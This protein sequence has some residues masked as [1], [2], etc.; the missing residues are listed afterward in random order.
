MKVAGTGLLP[1]SGSLV[2]HS[3]VSRSRV[4]GALAVVAYLLLLAVATAVPAQEP[5]RTA[6]LR[7]LAESVPAPNASPI[8]PVMSGRPDGPVQLTPGTIFR[9][10]RNCPDMVVVPAGAYMMGSAAGESERVQVPRRYR[11]RAEPRHEV[12]IPVPFAI[13]RNEL[14][15][16]DF[17]RFV[18]ATGRSVRGCWILTPRGWAFRPDLGWLNP[19]FPQSDNDPV[20]C[21]SWEDAH[22]YTYWLSAQ[23][24]Q[25]YRL[26]T[27]A[28]WEYVARA[29]T[30][31]ARP[32]GEEIGRNF[33]NC[34][35]C[36]SRWDNLR[37]A[38][39]RSFPD[40]GFRVHELLGNVE[41]WVQD[42][43]H[44][45]Y[46]GAPGDGTAWQEGSCTF[47]VFRGGAWLS[48]PE[49]VR[50]AHRN[51]ELPSFRG[52]FLGFRLARDVPL[53]TSE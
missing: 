29:G 5:F 6:A 19:G 53:P 50:S 38:P 49:A 22:A 2:S 48:A 34:R 24:R 52:N 12:E 51:R 25:S 17:A 46:A 10:C 40:N 15:R 41:E 20:V 18:E 39:V 3:L 4:P 43:W 33:A 36:G 8:R 45:D 1:L 23:T 9:D 35:G 26:P 16:V 28:E 32:W 37:T 44:E 47:R 7:P 42:C 27:E 31:T 21:V 11:G 13:G 14:R 30:T